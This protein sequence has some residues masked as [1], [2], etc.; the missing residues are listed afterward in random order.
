M[1]ARSALVMGVGRMENRNA[2]IS[3]AKLGPSRDC[4]VSASQFLFPSL[5]ESFSAMERDGR[6]CGASLWWPY[7]I[8]GWGRG[9]LKTAFRRKPSVWWRSW[10]K[11]MVG[12]SIL[13]FSATLT[14]TDCSLLWLHPWK[15]FRGTIRV[16][17]TSL[18]CRR[19][20]SEGRGFAAETQGRF[21]VSMLVLCVHP[22]L[23][24]QC[25]NKRSFNLNLPQLCFQ[26]RN[27]EDLSFLKGLGRNVFPKA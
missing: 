26:I 1:Y 2:K 24:I 11:P 14:S 16:V 20:G 4:Q 15:S 8:S 7:G 19:E 6:R 27:H 9:A 12:D 23:C 17:A 10:E 22:W 13:C 21:C 3:C 25:G 18:M 5:Q